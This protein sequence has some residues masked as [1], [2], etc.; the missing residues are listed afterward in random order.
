[1]F[2]I[3]DSCNE[4]FNG[5]IRLVEGSTIRDGR[6]E[7]CTAGCWTGVCISEHGWSAQDATVACTQLQLNFSGEKICLFCMT[8]LF[9][10]LI[11]IGLH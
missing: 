8:C 4:C 11:Q 7:V 10:A 6:L 9:N 5:S 2:P 1:M 3:L